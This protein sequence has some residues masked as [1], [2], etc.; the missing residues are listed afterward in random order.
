L[1]NG[2]VALNGTTAT[3]FPG[4]G[5]SGTDTFTFAASNGFNDSNLATGTVAVALVFTTNDGVPD[6]WRAARSGGNGTT[7]YEQSCA[8]CDPDGDGYDNAK[9]FIALTDP[10]DIRSAP[11]IFGWMLSGGEARLDFVSML[12]QKFAVERRD[13]LLTGSWSALTT[14]LWAIPTR[15]ASPIWT[16][17]RCG[18]VITVSES[19]RRPDF[20]G[21]G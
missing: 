9:E 20:F 10:L 19:S 21:R 5:Y 1:N 15:Q 13:D 2:T 17:G 18:P 12:G 16:A 8:S 6:C 11:R 7:T 4:V 3:Y 14:N